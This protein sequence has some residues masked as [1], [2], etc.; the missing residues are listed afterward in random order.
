MPSPKGK[1]NQEAPSGR[2]LAR[3][4]T[5]G[6]CV[7]VKI[8]VN[9]YSRILLPSLVACD[10]RHTSSRRKA[11]VNRRSSVKNEKHHSF[12]GRVAAYLLCEEYI[13]C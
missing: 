2:E 8:A 4:A 7:P 13:N 9:L 1:A 12:D 10:I 3:N 11:I 5:E 6:E